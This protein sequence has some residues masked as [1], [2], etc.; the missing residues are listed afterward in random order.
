MTDRPTPQQ[1]LATN[2]VRLVRKSGHLAVDLMGLAGAG[3]IVH[4]VG[5][6]YRPAGSI[7]A[8]LFLLAAAV[9]LTARRT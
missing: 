7:V 9:L 5:L 2:A 6:I 4:G 1:R 3:W 8:G